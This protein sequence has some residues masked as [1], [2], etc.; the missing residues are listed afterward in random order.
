MYIGKQKKILKK[1][2]SILAENYVK[3]YDHRMEIVLP[4]DKSNLYSDLSNMYY[5]D[6]FSNSPK[7]ELDRLKER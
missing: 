2:G 7:N 6:I 4:Y 5:G 3:G 1:M